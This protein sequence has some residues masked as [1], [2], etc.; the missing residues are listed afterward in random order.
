MAASCSLG[1]ELGLCGS[2]AAS[3]GQRLAVQAVRKH[4]AGGGAQGRS[5]HQQGELLQHLLTE[6]GSPRVC[7]VLLALQVSHREDAN[8]AHIVDVSPLTHVGRSVG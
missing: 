5:S 7:R 2:R 3:E 8:Y 4:S 1:A 6:G